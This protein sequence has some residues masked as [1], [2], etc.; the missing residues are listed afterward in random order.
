MTPLIWA[1][2]LHGPSLQPVH[3]LATNTSAPQTYFVLNK[4]LLYPLEITLI[5]F[6][7]LV[8]RVPSQWLGAEKQQTS[9]TLLMETTPRSPRWLTSNPR[10]TSKINNTVNSKV[11]PSR[12]RTMV[13]AM[14]LRSSRTDMGRSLLSTKH[15]SWTNRSGTISGLV[16]CS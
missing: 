9:T 2:G 6:R 16:Y 13:K 14:E 1:L 5:P 11:T 12:R 8:G 4:S 3:N 10:V 7:S 15:S